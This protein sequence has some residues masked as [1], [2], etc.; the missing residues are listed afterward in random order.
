[1]QSNPMPSVTKLPRAVGHRLLHLPGSVSG[2]KHALQRRLA[3]V[4]ALVDRLDP[5]QLKLGSTKPTLSEAVV[6]KVFR[7]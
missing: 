3:L 4:L 5:R 6:A 7:P 1:M 2:A